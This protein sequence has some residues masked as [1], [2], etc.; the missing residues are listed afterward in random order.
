VAVTTPG[1][2]A[3]ALAAMMVSWIWFKKPDVSMTMNGA[4]AGLVAITAPCYVVDP[5]PAMLIGLVEA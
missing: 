3:G 2:S 5:L 4:L 1:R